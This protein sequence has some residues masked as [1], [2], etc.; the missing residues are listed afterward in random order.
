MVV[1]SVVPSAVQLVPLSVVQS[2]VLSAVWLVV[3]KVVQFRGF[4]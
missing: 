1:E 2:V 4:P 3:P